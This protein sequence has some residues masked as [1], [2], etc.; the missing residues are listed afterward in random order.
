MTRISLLQCGDVEPNPGPPSGPSS[1]PLSHQE[2]LLGELSN[3]PG[4]DQWQVLWTAISSAP[5]GG[6]PGSPRGLL[7]RCL[8]CDLEFHARSM[9]RVWQHR[10][11]SGTYDAADG[12]STPGEEFGFADALLSYEGDHPATGR[13]DDLLS[14]GDVEANPGPEPDPPPPPDWLDNANPGLRLAF[15]APVGAPPPLSATQVAE[16]AALVAILSDGLNTPMVVDGPPGTPLRSASVS[17]GG[18]DT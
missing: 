14:N 8:I 1:G 4:R 10:C 6:E 11:P 5:D 13:G 3:D 7:L 16:V 12:D 2:W 15:T 9:R 17:V 18:D